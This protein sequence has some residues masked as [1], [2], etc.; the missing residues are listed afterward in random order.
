[1]AF[2]RFQQLGGPLKTLE[3]AESA[4]P[5]GRARKS[6]VVT[7]GVEMRE[8]ETYYPDN[9]TPT[10]HVF[11][12]RQEPWEIKGRFRDRGK[13][14]GV[15]FAKAKTEEVKAFYRDHQRCRITWGDIVSVVGLIT[16]FSPGRE[17]A[18]EVAWEM[19]IKVDSDDFAEKPKKRKVDTQKPVDYANRI[20][21][22]MRESLNKLPRDTSM[23][24]DIFDAVDSLV[25]VVTTATGAL[26]SAADDVASFE[27][28]LLG[29]LNRIDSAVAQVR[30]AVF[31]FKETF[32]SLEA[33]VALQRERSEENLRLWDSQTSAEEAVRETL[34]EL[35]VMDRAVKAAKSGKTRTT[36]EARQGDTWESISTQHYGT[37]DRAIDIIAANNVPA[38]SKPVPGV[39]YIIPV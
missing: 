25:S 12:D 15:G 2:W 38:G 17:S 37:P 31:V 29:Q 5:H 34:A 11:G 23:N 32:T 30:N 1:M 21:N 33:G 35:A 4:A 10:R 20:R 22:L 7:D 16:R 36:H 28:G 19:T 18:G 24:G 3:L 27:K 14:G 6:P 13:G 26:Q 39:E 8:S 9:D